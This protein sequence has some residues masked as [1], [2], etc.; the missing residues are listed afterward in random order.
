M[1]QAQSFWQQAYGLQALSDDQLKQILVHHKKDVPSGGRKL[2]EQAAD[3]LLEDLNQQVQLDSIINLSGLDPSSL[4]EYRFV[5]GYAT[6]T[7]AER[8]GLPYQAGP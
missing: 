7:A 4:P 2:L 5:N 6:E 1:A 3:A 8:A